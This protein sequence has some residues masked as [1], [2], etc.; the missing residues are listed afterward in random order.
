MPNLRSPVSIQDLR[1]RFYTPQ[2][3]EEMEKA[4]QEF[5]FLHH[6]V[7]KKLEPAK[8]REVITGSAGYATLVYVN[9]ILIG[10]FLYDV[11]KR[12]VELHGIARPD[13]HQFIPYHKRVKQ[14]IFHMILDD[15]FNTMDRDKVV[16]IQDPGN[17]GVRGFALMFGFRPIQRSKAG[18]VVWVLN[19]ASYKQR[20]LNGKEESTASHSQV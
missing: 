17:L 1:L 3:G 12:S 5:E 18:R 9:D 4:Y 19:R 7:V 20:F 14:K 13:M 2:V 8:L 11:Y 6:F 15:C 10:C 16:I